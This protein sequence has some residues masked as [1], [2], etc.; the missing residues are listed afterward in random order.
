M[1]G[2]DREYRMINIEYSILNR[3]KRSSLEEGGGCR[4][5]EQSGCKFKAFALNTNTSHNKSGTTDLLISPQ[6][7]TIQCLISIL[8]LSN[9]Y[10]ETVLRILYKN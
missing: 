10:N 4:G 9:I 2:E 6:G 3:K 1:R 8:E 7:E 5:S